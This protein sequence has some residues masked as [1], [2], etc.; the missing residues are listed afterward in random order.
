MFLAPI[1]IEADRWYY[2]T[3]SKQET[4]S[5]GASWLQLLINE[6]CFFGAFHVYYY[7]FDVSWDGAGYFL[8]KEGRIGFD[9]FVF[10]NFPPKKVFFSGI[11]QKHFPKTF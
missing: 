10:R 9:E 8:T 11:A 5:F 7:M 6:F 3:A 4:G 2:P 1:I